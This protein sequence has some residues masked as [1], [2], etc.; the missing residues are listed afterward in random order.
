M[1]QEA[2]KEEAK[3]NFG[4]S[5]VKE[6]NKGAKFDAEKAIQS[7]SKGQKE[8]YDKLV[9]MNL[10]NVTL[11]QLIKAAQEFGV[12]VDA[13]ASYLAADDPDNGGDIGEP[14]FLT[15]IAHSGK[16]DSVDKKQAKE[17]ASDK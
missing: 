7:L 12:D 3:D 5:M 17:K 1:A 16:V 2:K 13:A 11:E 10:K 15:S 14:N 9:A 8:T 4:S 6:A